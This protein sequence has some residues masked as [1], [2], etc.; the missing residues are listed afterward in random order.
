MIQRRSFLSLCLVL[1]VATAAAAAEK[2]AL[3]DRLVYLQTNLLVEDN[4]AKAL[5]L[6]ERAAKA[7][8]TG[9]VITDSKFDRLGE[10]PERYAVNARAL[11]ASVRANGMALYPVVCGVGY[12]GG[13]L[14]QDPDLAEGL[15]LK[16]V[17]FVV[18]DD[19]L[20]QVDADPATKLPGGGF[21]G[22]NAD[23]ALAWNF[24]D[25]PGVASFLDR[26]VKHGGEASLRMSDVGAAD[27][28]HGNCRVMREVP[29]SPW[30]QYRVTA[31]VRTAA[32]ERPGN[33][34]CVVLAADGAPLSSQQWAFARDQ[35]W[36]R[37]RLTFNSLAHER[38]RL[39]A[40]CW[41]GGS[42]S[43]WWDDLAIEEVGILNLLRRPGAPLTVQRGDGTALVEGRDLEAVSDPACGRTPWPGAYEVDHDPPALRV[44]DRATLPAGTRLLVSG[45]HAVIDVEGSVACCLAEPRVLA[46]MRDQV[47]AVRDLLRP[48][49]YFLGHDEIRQAGWC[50]ACSGRP[51]GET[52][53]AHMR[54]CLAMVR[55]EAPG[56]R[57]FCWSD[58]FDP[59]HNAVKGF[60]RVNGDLAGSWKGLDPDVVVVN[61]NSGAQ[62]AESMAFFAGH[63]HRQILAGYYDGDPASISAWLGDVPART[64]ISGVM[65]TTW[66]ANYDALEAFLR[67]AAGD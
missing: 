28:Q 52:L 41:Q 1:T 12:M 19:G 51:P 26:S 39:Y 47:R 18:G 15:P 4:L 3:P 13:V 31:W 54:D 64:P 2:A 34:R 23:R 62:R 35:D 36:T 53:A 40:G 27:P 57:L 38:V 61:W 17:P 29:V 60:Y 30:R 42:G 14:A 5:A 49:G 58:M 8:Y 66:A 32:L 44:Q 33:A 22:G 7:G 59:T 25:L 24:Q 11:A 37:Y 67:S 9:L 48:D 50:A 46:L 55:A 45:Y 56:A 6:V 16:D 20:A 65:Y 63:G 21:E 43:I 10:L